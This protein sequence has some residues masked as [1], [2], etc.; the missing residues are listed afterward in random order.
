[1]SL[2]TRLTRLE[3]RQPA[4]NTRYTIF[5]FINGTLPE[6]VKLEDIDKWAELE[7]ALREVVRAVE[8]DSVEARLQRLMTSVTTPSAANPENHDDFEGDR[9]PNSR[10]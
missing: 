6:N 7:P 10:R 4:R 1:M 8:E 9:E 5:D 2:K 3:S